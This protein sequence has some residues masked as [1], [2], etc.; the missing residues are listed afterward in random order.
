MGQWKFRE[1]SSVQ[2][3]SSAGPGFLLRFLGLQLL[4][5]HRWVVMVSLVGEIRQVFAQ[6]FSAQGQTWVLHYRLCHLPT[7]PVPVPGTDHSTLHWIQQSLAHSAT[8][9]ASVEVF[10]I[11]HPCFWPKTNSGGG[12]GG[13]WGSWTPLGLGPFQDGRQCC[14]LDYTPWAGLQARLWLYQRL[15]C[16]WLGASKTHVLPWFLLSLP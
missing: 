11:N 6:E 2:A 1:F 14:G 8:E 4:W 12:A 7:V 3:L 15:S 16:G 13:L 10:W 9:E 5:Y